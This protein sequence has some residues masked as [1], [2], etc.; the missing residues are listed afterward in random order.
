MSS[1]IETTTGQLINKIVCD[2]HH[3]L[4]PLPIT[5][6]LWPII[7]PNWERKLLW[8]QNVFGRAFCVITTGYGQ[9]LWGTM[10][11]NDISVWPS[12]VGTKEINK[13]LLSTFLLPVPPFPFRLGH[14]ACI[15][16]NAS[17]SPLRE[18]AC[19][20]DHTVV[21]CPRKL[22]VEKVASPRLE[23]GT[24]RSRVESSTN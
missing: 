4:H 20:W 6:K 3:P 1:Y 11:I 7:N 14:K 22:R 8:I 16:V 18:L 2:W 24:S 12:A 9:P 19:Q 5:L 15:A 21:P 23:P 17:T 10:I 13:I